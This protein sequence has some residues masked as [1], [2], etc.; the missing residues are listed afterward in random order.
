MSYIAILSLFLISSLFLEIYF[1]PH[2]FDSIKERLLASAIIFIIGI[3][4]DTYAVSQQHW[5]FPGPG[6]V[7]VFIGKLPMEEYLFFLIAP[8]FAVTTATIIREKI[9]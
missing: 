4:W 3:I 9:K 6:L 5:I 8:Y 2:L 1:K 7:G